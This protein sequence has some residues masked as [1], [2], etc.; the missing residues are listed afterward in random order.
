MT[1]VIIGHSPDD[2]TWRLI[3]LFAEVV[4]VTL[5]SMEPGFHFFPAA[6]SKLIMPSTMQNNQ[7]SIAFNLSE[8]WEREFLLARPLH[9]PLPEAGTGLMPLPLPTN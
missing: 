4:E 5:Q 7:S 9:L 8:L 2:S 3:A 1:M 6:R